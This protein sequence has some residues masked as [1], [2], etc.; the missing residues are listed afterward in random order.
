[1]RHRPFAVEKV[2][3]E[4]ARSP[5]E[6]WR[7]L[8]WA[9]KLQARRATGEVSGVSTEGGESER[10]ALMSFGKDAAH[11]PPPPLEAH[12]NGG[13]LATEIFL[14]AAKAFAQAGTDG[15]RRL[16]APV[17]QASAEVLEGLLAEASPKAPPTDPGRLSRAIM[18]ERE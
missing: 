5:A 16:F 7:T 18:G 10:W 4:G 9:A 15:R 14:G 2:R 8:L 12:D 1:M 6:F 13:R 11:A 3:R 17:L